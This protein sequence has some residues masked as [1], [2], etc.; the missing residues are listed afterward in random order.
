MEYFV[1]DID[2][3]FISIGFLKIRWY[4]LMFASAFITSY[5]LMN[6][7]YKREGK[8]VKEVDDLLWYV[9]I[10]TIVGARLGHCLFNAPEYYL[11][12]PLKILAIWEGG[13][14]SHGG[15]AGIVISLYLYQRRVK[16][17]YAWFLDR[18]AVVCA[19]GAIFVRTG[20]FFNSEIV[21]VPTSVP[22]AIIFKRIDSLPRHPVQLYEAMSYALIFL[23]LLTMYRKIEDRIRPGVIFSTSLVTI[24][25]ARFFLEFVKT[26]QADYANDFWMSTGQMLSIPFFL[27]GMSYIIFS[28]FKKRNF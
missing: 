20:N 5:L 23:L 17:S 13:L 2:P 3:V 21:G 19:L 28:V 10:G 7:I 11:T 6:W 4:G 1:W 16:E 15:I 25:T 22:W 26:K 8:D 14:A 9:A 24:F 12:H 18:V 27:A